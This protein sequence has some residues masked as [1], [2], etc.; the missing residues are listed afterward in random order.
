MYTDA[1][2]DINLA[3]VGLP[4]Q[5]LEAFNWSRHGVALLS[6]IMWPRVYCFYFPA[7]VPN[8]AAPLPSHPISIH[9]LACI[10]GSGGIFGGAVIGS[11]VPGVP[12]GPSFGSFCGTLGGD[13]VGSAATAASAATVATS[14]SAAA[15]AAAVGVAVTVAADGT[16]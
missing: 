15:A 3:A 1:C 13:A 16:L 14:S 7:S 9:V 10:V 8:F 2:V 12:V 4:E 6:P 5:Y 11:M